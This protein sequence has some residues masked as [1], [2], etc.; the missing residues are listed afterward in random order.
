[1]DR[2]PNLHLL[3]CIVGT[4]CTYR[5]CLLQLFYVYALNMLQFQRLQVNPAILL[6]TAIDRMIAGLQDMCFCLCLFVLYSHTT[7]NLDVHE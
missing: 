5:Y 3:T 1:M 2:K 6:Y 4:E 7:A